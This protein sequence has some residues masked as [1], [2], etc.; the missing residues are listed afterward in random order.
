MYY[1]NLTKGLKEIIRKSFPDAEPKYK[2]V[3][4]L[5]TNFELVCYLLWMLDE[6]QKFD[7]SA[8]R[9]RWMGY[10]QAMMETEGLMLNA[11]NR[12]LTR[13]DIDSQ[14]PV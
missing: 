13:L 4:N 3:D 8:R 9:G 6:L 7:D 11:D 12:K 14:S 2:N 5:E 10:V 1:P